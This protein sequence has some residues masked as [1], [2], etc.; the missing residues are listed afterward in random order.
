M[1]SRPRKLRSRKAGLPPGSLVHIG[2]IKTG[3]PAYGLIDFDESAVIEDSADNAAALVGRPRQRATRW[4]N[5]YG[6]HDPAELSLIGQAV[7]LH[8]LV[9]EDIM[10]YALRQKIDS[11]EDYL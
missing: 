10:N 6:A 5:V 2:E 11:Y 4:A 1:S 3:A 7:G 9:L 8:P